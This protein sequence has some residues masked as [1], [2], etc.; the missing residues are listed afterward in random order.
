MSEQPTTEAIDR[1]CELLG[2]ECNHFVNGQCATLG[3][4]AKDAAGRFEKPHRFVGCDHYQ[5]IMALRS[6]GGARELPDMVPRSR[7][8]AANKDWLDEKAAREAMLSKSVAW[9]ETLLAALRSAEARLNQPVLNNTE[10]AGNQA[11]NILRA[12]IKSALSVIRTALKYEPSGS[13]PTPRAAL[14][15]LHQIDREIF[16]PE[17]SAEPVA[18]YHNGFGVLE[19]SRIRRVGWKPLYAHPS[20]EPRAEQVQDND[21]DV[22]QLSRAFTIALLLLRD[23]YW[24]Q[25]RKDGASVDARVRQFFE[26]YFKEA[27]ENGN[28]TPP[29][30]MPSPPE[31]GG[32]ARL[33]EYAVAAGDA[34]VAGVPQ[35]RDGW[36]IISRIQ[37]DPPNDRWMLHDAD[38]REKESRAEAE[39]LAVVNTGMDFAVVPIKWRTPTKVAKP[40]HTLAC[41]KCGAT[42]EMPV[43]DGRADLVA[44]TGWQIDSGIVTCPQCSASN[45]RGER[46]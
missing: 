29:V 41:A 1:A 34:I 22:G 33:M 37:T 45:G 3:C 5:A 8:D 40:A 13:A 2:Q 30:Y 25:S 44:V 20:P 26:G 38:E 43:K 14:N 18:W 7:Y 9:I 28:A 27:V 21:I 35:W 12:D 10:S 31:P 23:Y 46:G 16:F 15:E 32:K 24:S 39:Q 19:L 11:A 6:S 42:A 36:A 17:P 4:H